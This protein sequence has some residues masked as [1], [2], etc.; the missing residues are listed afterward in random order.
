M[1]EAHRI[2][3][4]YGTSSLVMLTVHTLNSGAKTFYT[5]LKFKHCWTSPDPGTQVWSKTV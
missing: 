2:I 3:A 4:D 1:N 5:A